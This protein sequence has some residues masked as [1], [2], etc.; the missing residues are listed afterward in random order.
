MTHQEIRFGEKDECAAS[1]VLM[2]TICGDMIG[3][4]FEITPTHTTDFELFN[5]RTHFTDDTV[6]TIAI[7][8]ALTRGADF[9]ESLQHWCRAY[10]TAGYGAMFH[11]WIFSSSPQPYNSYGNDSAMRVSAVGAKAD[12]F[13]EALSL[14]RATAEVTHNHPEGIKGAVAVAAAVFLAL[15]VD[16]EGNHIFEKEDIR[17]ILTSLTGYDLSRSYESIKADYRFQISCQKSVPEAIIAFLDSSDYEDAVRK[18]VAYG[19]D[20]DTQAAIAG[21]IAAAYYGYIPSEIFAEATLRLDMNIL[22]VIQDFND[23]IDPLNDD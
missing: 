14:A 17:E 7:A 1:L 18:A 15:R 20:A 11:S 10:P 19:G 4:F 5:N 12:T 13:M 21:G 9:T 3:S 6:C 2:G 16:T 22:K 8:D 23:S